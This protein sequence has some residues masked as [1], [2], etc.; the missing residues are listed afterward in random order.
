MAAALGD[1]DALKEL[2]V[3]NKRALHA[4]D[5]NGW[6]PLHEAIRGGHYDAVK[7]LV[8]SGADYN[9]VTNQG[10]GVSPYHIAVRSWSEDHPVALY[11]EGLGAIDVGPDL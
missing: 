3:E 8:E 11:L 7:L 2:A 9:A 5:K 4:S 6:Q 1:V 10:D